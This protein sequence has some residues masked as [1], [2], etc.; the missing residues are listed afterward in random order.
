M[1]CPTGPVTG[2]NEETDADLETAAKMRL[3][4]G[5][6]RQVAF[7]GPVDMSIKVTVG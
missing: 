5:A 2:E 1:D 3:Q 7:F 4:Y 6:R